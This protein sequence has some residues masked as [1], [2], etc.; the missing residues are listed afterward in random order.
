M[1]VRHELSELNICLYEAGEVVLRVL[2]CRIARLDLAEKGEIARSCCGSGLG[3]AG[4]TLEANNGPAR[5]KSFSK[6][7]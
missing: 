6:A 3:R 7:E 2:L 5:P 1:G 4:E